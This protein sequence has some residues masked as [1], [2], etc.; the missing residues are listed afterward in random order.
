MSEHT[1]S[2]PGHFIKQELEIR[3]MSVTEAASLLKIGRSAL[4]KV[5]N[6]KAAVSVE[7]ALKLELEAFGL[8]SANIWL[9]LQN[10]YNLGKARKT[11]KDEI[12]PIYK[13]KAIPALKKLLDEEDFERTC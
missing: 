1:P 12:K 6:E 4:S 10:N 3:E 9:G 2:H 5:I 11:F 7:L 13:V 8:S